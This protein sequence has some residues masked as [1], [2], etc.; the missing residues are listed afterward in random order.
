[1]KNIGNMKVGRSKVMVKVNNFGT[2]FS[3]LIY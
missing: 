1:M 3:R 2:D